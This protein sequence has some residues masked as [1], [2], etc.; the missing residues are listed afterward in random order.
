[1]LYNKTKSMILPKI[2]VNKSWQ[3]LV[4]VFY[5]IHFH[6]INNSG[7]AA[8]YKGPQLMTTND[9]TSH[10]TRGRWYPGQ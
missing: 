10:N 6:D 9:H 2:Q 3:F 7:S 5:N 4:L 1:V 8:T